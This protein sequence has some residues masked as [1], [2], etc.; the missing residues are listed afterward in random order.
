MCL[1]TCMYSN[2]PTSFELFFGLAF[3]CGYEV[4]VIQKARA[5]QL[6][7]RKPQAESHIVR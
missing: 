3:Q 1:H 6:P 2:V 4:T 5:L 7:Q